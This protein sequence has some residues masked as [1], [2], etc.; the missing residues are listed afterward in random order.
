MCCI[1]CVA[2]IPSHSNP[3]KKKYIKSILTNTFVKTTMT[4]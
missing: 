1:E 2:N 3:S 4:L